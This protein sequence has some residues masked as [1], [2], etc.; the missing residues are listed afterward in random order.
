MRIQLTKISADLDPQRCFFLFFRAFSVDLD[1]DP[2]RIRD[3]KHCSTMF[4]TD[5]VSLIIYLCI[6]NRF[7]INRVL[8][9]CSLTILNSQDGYL[10]GGRCW[11]AG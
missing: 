6:R 7:R 4:C 2:V 8:F 11:K 10:R 9:H 3:P 5:P 1:P